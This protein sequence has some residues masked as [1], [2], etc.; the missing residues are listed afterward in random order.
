[1]SS[2]EQDLIADLQG[3][4]LITDCLYFA[5]LRL[6]LRGNQEYTDRLQSFPVLLCSLRT[7]CLSM[8]E[9]NHVL[10]SFRKL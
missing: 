5:T 9:F 2:I 6:L 7:P 3:L 1:V 8:L 10:N 4:H